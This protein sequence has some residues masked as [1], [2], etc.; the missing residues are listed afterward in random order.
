MTGLINGDTGWIRSNHDTRYGRWEIRSRSFNTGTTGGTYH[1]LHLIWPTSEN[2]P[3]DGEYDFLENFNPDDT[4]AG[5]WIHYPHNEGVAVQ[6]EGG[7][8]ATPN[9]KLN[10]WHNYAFEWTPT[11]IAGFIDGVEV[12]RYSGG[13]NSIRKNIQDMPLGSYTMQLDNFTGNGGLRPASFEVDWYRFYP[14]P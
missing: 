11:H 9:V 5:H 2:W 1:P 7:W 6:Q 8:C 14:L 13:A 10:D 3:E 12:Y 4:C